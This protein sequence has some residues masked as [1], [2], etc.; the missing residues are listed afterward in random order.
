M[1]KRLHEVYLGISI[2]FLPFGFDF[3]YNFLRYIL[4]SKI[5]AD[6]TMYLIAG[7]FFLLVYLSKKFYN[8]KF[9]EIFLG[10]GTFFN[11]FLYDAVYN[12][13]LYITKSLLWTELT[14]YGLS[15]IFFVL[16]L[17]TKK[18]ITGHW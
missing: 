17:R 13:I 18:E 10:I 2:F 9:H 15:G 3:I 16:Y 11:P 8:G 5:Y 7:F 12:G 6:A 14:L 4:H 1:Q